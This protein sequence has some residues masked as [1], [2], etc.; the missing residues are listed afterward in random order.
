VQSGTAEAYMMS[1]RVS[2]PAVDDEIARAIESIPIEDREGIE[3]LL[4]AAPNDLHQLAA[5]RAPV[6]GARLTRRGGAHVR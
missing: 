3:A 4:S 1:G 6:Q 2:C 5:P